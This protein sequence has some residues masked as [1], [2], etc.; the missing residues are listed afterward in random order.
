MW[1]D[2]G[3]YNNNSCFNG[4]TI[5]GTTIPVRP[6]ELA[7]PLCW[8]TLHDFMHDE[9]AKAAM[10][11]PVGIAMVAGKVINYNYYF[12]PIAEYFVLGGG[13]LQHYIF[14]THEA[15]TYYTAVKHGLFNP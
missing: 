10:K 1:A 7:N 5:P 12:G 8:M 6:L 14:D 4:A 3:E 11:D 15:F 2:V 9:L 13:V